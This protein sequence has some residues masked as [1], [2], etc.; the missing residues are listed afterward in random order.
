MIPDITIHRC[1]NEKGGVDAHAQFRDPKPSDVIPSLAP[2]TAPSYHTCCVA[3][4]Y[5]VA[6]GNV[7]WLS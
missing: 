3:W 6:A 4:R 2:L 7:I 1:E 5:L